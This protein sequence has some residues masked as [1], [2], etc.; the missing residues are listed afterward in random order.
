MK[1]FITFFLFFF[2]TSTSN[3]E[4]R[5]DQLD[6]LFNELKINNEVLT[7][8]IEQKIWKIWSTHPTN[9]ILTNRLEDG[10]K[11]VREKNLSKAVK[12]FTEI[13]NIDPM[14]AEAWNK[15]A[16]VLYMMAD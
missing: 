2:V 13:I 12:V 5:D 3:A 4:N 1:K 15:R 11:L 9:K 8:K 16:T 14:W 10:S 7:Y 6:Q